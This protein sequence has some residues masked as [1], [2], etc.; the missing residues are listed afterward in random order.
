MSLAEQ[1]PNKSPFRRFVSKVAVESES[2]TLPQ[3][4]PRKGN[5]K[6]KEN[7]TSV[8]KR[9][10]SKENSLGRG[11]SS[12]SK[13]YT[14][15]GG[16]I[17]KRGLV[18]PG[19]PRGSTLP[20]LSSKKYLSSYQNQVLSHNKSVQYHTPGSHIGGAKPIKIIPRSGA[21]ALKQIEKLNKGVERLGS[22]GE[23]RLGTTKWQY[24]L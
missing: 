23:N 17:S 13:D 24:E 6:N 3:I 5:R 7:L 1:F 4:T 21:H 16:Q 19:S 14:V 20:A 8:K 10:G 12:P 9:Q 15:G 18:P 2:S 11:G 22:L